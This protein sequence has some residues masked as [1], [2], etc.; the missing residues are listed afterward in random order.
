MF[1]HAPQPSTT[2]TRTHPNCKGLQERN[3]KDNAA[4]AV[5]NYLDGAPATMAPA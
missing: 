5:L 4:N 3:C 2:A 1:S